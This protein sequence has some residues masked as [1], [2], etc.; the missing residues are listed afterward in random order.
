MYF[1]CGSTFKKGAKFVH[2][3]VVSKVPET[4]DTGHPVLLKLGTKSKSEDEKK[5]IGKTKELGTKFFFSPTLV[6]TGV[7]PSISDFLLPVPS[8]LPIYSH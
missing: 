7:S 2:I 8:L 1:E 6:L 4:E 5:Y 3:R